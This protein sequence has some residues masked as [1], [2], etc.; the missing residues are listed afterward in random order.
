MIEWG[1]LVKHLLNYSQLDSPAP[2]MPRATRLATIP[3]VATEAETRAPG[4]GA[5]FR[6]GERVMPLELFFDLVFVLAL[7]QCTALMSENP[8]WEGLGQGVLIL[9]LLWWSW[10]AYSW[11][12]SVLDPEEGAVRL[13]I[14][15]VMAAFLIAALCIPEAFD[16]LALE[17]AVAYAVV[18]WS[19]IGLMLLASRDDPALRRSTLGLSVGTT[20]G[21]SLLIVGAFLDS[22]GQAAVWGLA[23]ALDMLE[24][25]L[26]GGEGWRLVPGHFAERHGL[27]II[28]AL[29]E[30]IVAI[31]VG[32]EGA[33]TWGIAGA[34]ALGIA[35]AAALW[36]LYFDVVALVSARRLARATTGLEQNALARDSYS[37]IHFL[38]VAGIVLSAL[39]LKKTLGDVDDPLKFVIEFAL[40]GGVAIYLLGLVAFRFRHVRSINRQRLGLALVLLALIPLARELPAVASVGLVVALLWA[41]IVYETR[42]Y[43]ERRA[44]TRHGDLTPGR[45]GDLP[46]A[47]S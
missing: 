7:T 2:S 25:Y 17:F 30:S 24:P 28:I 36:W 42:S 44:Q 29:G 41:L 37:Y 14:F 33:L 12:T 9:A 20:I 1:G 15:A 38:M 6:E 26:F 21:V 34:A 16:G 4:L 27:I 23:L 13:I 35:L 18:R 46:S 31:G 22:G 32:A 10:V 43:G 47:V 11:S 8:T 40:L 19:Q 5:A 45:E 3:A 39:G